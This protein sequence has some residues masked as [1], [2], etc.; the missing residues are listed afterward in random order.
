[1]IDAHDLTSS[2][3]IQFFALLPQQLTDGGHGF[4]YHHQLE[5]ALDQAVS[6]FQLLMRRGA[7][8][9]YASPRWT[10]LFDRWYKWNGAAYRS[11][12]Q[13][14]GDKGARRIF[15]SD[16]CSLLEGVQL[17]ITAHLYARPLDELWLILRHDFASLKCNGAFHRLAIRT[18]HRKFGSRLKILTDSYSLQQALTSRLELPVS[19]LPIPHAEAPIAPASPTVP[20]VL[21][22]YWSGQPRLAK[23]WNQIRHILTLPPPQGLQIQLT[24]SE[25]SKLQSQTIQVRHLPP[26]LS[27]AQ[28]WEELGNCDLLLLPYDP[29]I[30]RYSTSGI[31]VEG[32]IR[33]KIPLVSAGTWLASELAR[34]D[35]EALI[36][37]WEDPAFWERCHELAHDPEIAAKLRQMQ[38]AYRAFHTLSQFSAK[39]TSLL[40]LSH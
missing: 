31:F 18:L 27:H 7:T 4:V 24:A 39:L 23:G 9:S 1:M 2:P 12:F 20:G 19:L 6:S 36:V 5:K 13:T 3:P 14:A 29:V 25:E 33:G 40:N 34:F 15:L 30:Y 10:P 17:C 35:L 21:R 38:S 32:M 28:Y 8:S 16:G 11:L 37:D 26:I 22:C